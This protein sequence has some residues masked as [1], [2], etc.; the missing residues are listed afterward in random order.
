MQGVFADLGVYLLVAGVEFDTYSGSRESL[1]DVLAGP[2][3]EDVGVLAL[4]SHFNSDFIGLQST[5]LDATRN[6]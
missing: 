6:R 3:I 1:A 5:I 2:G 4:H